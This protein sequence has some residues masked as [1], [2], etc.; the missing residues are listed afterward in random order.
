L[1]KE[2]NING[3]TRSF[4]GVDRIFDLLKKLGIERTATGIAVAINE[5][6]IPRSQWA[7]HKIVNGDQV[8]IVNAVQGG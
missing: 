3:E 2:L 7:S 5:H 6:V 4:S 8:E 1:S